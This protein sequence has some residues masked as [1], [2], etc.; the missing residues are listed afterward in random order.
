MVVGKVSA[1]APM[2]PRV[3]IFRC[4]AGV[5]HWVGM[6]REPSVISAVLW[7]LLVPLI[8]NLCLFFS[9]VC[10]IITTGG[11]EPTGNPAAY[12]LA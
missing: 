3:A 1:Q 5:T 10:T 6:P 2:R 9:P 8:T 12:D 11:F 4:C 7:L